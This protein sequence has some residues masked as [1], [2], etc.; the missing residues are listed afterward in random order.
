MMVEVIKED[1]EG[2]E[3]TEM[4]DIDAPQILKRMFPDPLARGGVGAPLGASRWLG[5]SG[6]ASFVRHYVWS[7]GF[8]ARAS[9]S[10]L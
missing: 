3:E 5:Y 2:V 8:L 7:S 4:E 9:D 6:L 10:R 1:E